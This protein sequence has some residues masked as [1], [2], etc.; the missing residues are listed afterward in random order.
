MWNIVH[1]I[2]IVQEECQEEMLL[3]GKKLS[4][5]LRADGL[6]RRVDRENGAVK[7]GG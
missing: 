3:S 7:V 1:I 6:I 2:M 4:D 5:E